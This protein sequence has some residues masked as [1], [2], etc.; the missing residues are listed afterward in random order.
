MILSLRGLDYE[1]K[2]INKAIKKEVYYNEDTN[3]LI[4]FTPL[5]KEL[6]TES[7]CNSISD[8]AYFYLINTLN[9]EEG[10]VVEWSQVEGTTSDYIIYYGLD[11]KELK[12]KNYKG[13]M[14]ELVSHIPNDAISRKYTEVKNEKCI[15]IQCNQLRRVLL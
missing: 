3:N 6:S 5:S 15:P 11:V 12:A 7:I 14:N 2:K 13:I 1:L 9:N 10:L 8:D 4:V